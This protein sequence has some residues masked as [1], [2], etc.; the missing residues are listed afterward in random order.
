MNKYALT[1]VTRPE[2]DEKVRKELLDSVTKKMGEDVKEELWGVRDL[3]YPIQK[4]GK[5]YYAH[6]FFQVEPNMIDPLDK[7]IKLEEDII[8]HL[9]VRIK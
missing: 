6:Y 9:I 5:G 3:S 1:I 8:R 7:F 2:M 4:L